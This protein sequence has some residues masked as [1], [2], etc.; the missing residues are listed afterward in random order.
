MSPVL[1]TEALY[2]QAG[3]M[4]P[5]KAGE[6]SATTTGDEDED[7]D[8]TM[9][10]QK[11]K[12]LLSVHASNK[13]WRATGSVWQQEES[14][15]AGGKTVDGM[16]TVRAMREHSQSPSVRSSPSSIEA[17]ALRARHHAMQ[18][19]MSQKSALPAILG[20]VTPTIDVCTDDDEPFDDS[21]A[22]AGLEGGVIAGGGEIT[23]ETMGEED[24]PIPRSMRDIYKISNRN[25]RNKKAG[26]PT[27]ERGVTPTSE[28]EREELAQAEAVRPPSSVFL[29]T[30]PCHFT[31]VQTAS[32]FVSPAAD[33]FFVPP[34]LLRERGLLASPYFDDGSPGK[35]QRT[36]PLSG[37]DS[38]E[39]VPQESTHASAASR[40]QDSAVIQAVGWIQPP[41]AVAAETKGG[42]GY[43]DAGAKDVTQYG[44]DYSAVGAIGAL[45]PGAQTA[46]N[47]FF[48]GA[49]LAGSQGTTQGVS[50][51]DQQRSKGKGNFKSRQNRSRQER[52]EKKDGGRTHSYRNKR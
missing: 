21:K 37:R 12:R 47:P 8:P 26:S 27:P 31:V 6:S 46:P 51:S 10:D 36:K 38:E 24:F 4:T 9:P 29:S 3:W 5:V 7:D 42:G 32:R 14:G 13:N 23:S 22:S 28:K 30:D 39:S 41:G 18:I 1:G 49:A 15:G 25:R 45:D 48:S 33:M 34:Q 52:P 44:F 35:R 19:R 50:K 43:P 20:L 17:D 16:G 2:K 40:E 11:P